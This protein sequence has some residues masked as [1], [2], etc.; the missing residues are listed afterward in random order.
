MKIIFFFLLSFKAFPVWSAISNSIVIQ[1]FTTSQFYSNGYISVKDNF[2]QV[3]IYPKA[4]LEELTKSKIKTYENVLIFAEIDIEKLNKL[5][6]ECINEF[7]SNSGFQKL[8][9]SSL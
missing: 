3:K 4:W 8:C 9:P 5:H 6:T 1:G 7:K 2:K